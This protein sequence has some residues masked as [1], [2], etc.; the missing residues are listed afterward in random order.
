MLFMDIDKFKDI[1]DTLGHKVGDLVLK[2]VSKRL[3]MILRESDTVARVG[4]DEFVVLLK[5]SNSNEEVEHVI[6]KIKDAIKAPLTVSKETLHI[7]ISIGYAFYPKDAQSVTE[8]I[9]MAD[10]KMF[11]EKFDRG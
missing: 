11:V 9:T 7:K 2:E 10:K 8:L 6:K 4:G 5:Y 1:N 3:K